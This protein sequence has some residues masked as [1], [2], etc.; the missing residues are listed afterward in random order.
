[1]RGAVAKGDLMSPRAALFSTALVLGVISVFFP[2]VAVFAFL[3]SVIALAAFTRF[4][5]PRRKWIGLALGVSLACSGFGLYRFIL[6]EAMQ[7]IIEARGRDS[8]NKAVSFLREILFA[9]DATRR[10]AWIDPDGDQVGSAALLVELAGGTTKRLRAAPQSPPLAPRHAPRVGTETGPVLDVSGYLYVI[11]LPGIDGK[12]T[13]RPNDPID[14]ELAERRW[15]AYAWPAQADLPQQATFFIDEHERI[16]Q[17]DNRKPDG[18]L[19][20]VGRHRAPTCEDALGPGRVNYHPWKDKKPRATL[21]GDK[22]VEA[23]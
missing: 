22:Q 21:P 10:Y 13:A 5:H 6:E 14:E 7:G 17:S 23:R 1:M 11:C 19:R 20:L 18:G 4:T 15:I 8:S 12:W 2:L 3:S 9:Q 16:L